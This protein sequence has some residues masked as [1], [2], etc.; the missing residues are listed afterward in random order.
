MPLVPAP[1]LP[2]R[3]LVRRLSALLLVVGLAVAAPAAEPKIAFDLPAAPAER[4]LKNFSAQSGLEVLFVTELAADVSTNAV[5]G[6]FTAKAAMDRMLAGTPLAASQDARTG[7]MKIARIAD[8]NAGRAAPRPSAAR[9]PGN[10]ANADDRADAAVVLSPF[11]VNAAGDVGYLAQNTLGGTRLNTALKDTAAPISVLTAEFLA[12]IAA[13]TVLEAMKYGINAH[14]DN[15]DQSPGNNAENFNQTF[16]NIRIRGL[17]GATRTQDYFGRLYETDLY[18]VERIDQSRGPNSILFGLGS[19]AGVINSSTKQAHYA[20]NATTLSARYDDWNDGYRASLDHNQVLLKNRLAVRLNLLKTEEAHWRDFGHN[21]QNRL[22]LAGKLKLH[23]RVELRADFER[24]QQNRYRPRPFIGLDLISYWQQQGRPIYDGYRLNDGNP[25][26]DLR[27]AQIVAPLGIPGLL[28]YSGANSGIAVLNPIGVATAFDARN[29]ARGNGV[30]QF[31]NP[32]FTNF[33]FIPKTADLLGPWISNDHDFKSLS[34]FLNV[35]VARDLNAEFAVNRQDY[36]NVYQG[37]HPNWLRINIDP[38]AYLPVAGSDGFPIANPYVGRYYVESFLEHRPQQQRV[39]SLRGTLSYERPLGRWARVR[40]A[41]LYERRT[42][43]TQV[44]LNEAYW[45]KDAAAARPEGVFN[46]NPINTANYAFHRFYLPAD[47]LASG[48]IAV[49]MPAFNSRT[50]FLLPNGTTQTA[51]SLVIP[52]GAIRNAKDEQDSLMAVTQLYLLKDRVVLTGGIRRE[53]LD[54]FRAP[55]RINARGFFEVAPTPATPESSLSATTHNVGAVVH[56]KPWL[57]VFANR[58]I[59]QDLPGANLVLNAD[60]KSL[61][62]GV[63]PPLREGKTQD[64]GV[65]FDLFQGRVFATATYYETSVADDLVTANITAGISTPMR[66][67]WQSLVDAGVVP[68]NQASAEIGAVADLTD[69]ATKGYEFEVI[70]NPTTNL[71]LSVNYATTAAQLSNVGKRLRPY[72][73]TH[74]PLW[75][76]GTN[77]DLLLAQDAATPGPDFGNSR[78]YVPTGLPGA[79][80]TAS[81]D[82]VRESV[83][84]IEDVFYDNLAIIDGT[85]FR[86]QSRHRLNFRAG[87]SFREGRLKGF[88]FG[89]GAR[90][91]KG[92]VIDVFSPQAVINGGLTD[93]S[94]GRSIAG[95]KIFRAELEQ[96]YDLS[97]GYQ[98]KLGARVRWRVQVNVNN[99]LDNQRLIV[100]L[101]NTNT[102]ADSRVLMRDPRQILVTNTFSF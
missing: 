20:R 100:N 17:P 64:F 5:K 7:A 42:S 77:G 78:D 95:R 91:Q 49:P 88:D 35:R 2:L 31:A 93:P 41:G 54:A 18:N 82:T 57:S 38:N 52:R 83:S 47:Q 12:D 46:P 66:L 53:Q 4:S 19:A 99:V 6:E 39:T 32:I 80:T 55:S 94:N 96:L 72:F 69:S 58:A 44:S 27:P 86:G 22:S 68:R 48:R 9:P 43:T 15:D 89:G 81:R 65:R 87:Y 71:R 13:T 50:T 76:A 92:R 33:A 25:A 14:E 60:P 97:L 61:D 59:S 36:D 63:R 101:L 16:G 67:I 8:P 70:A 10:P 90:L 26:N 84:D 75:L 30:A 37:A 98:R 34:A 24:S 45:V 56:L 102:E 51:E 79:T 74:K 40:A 73:D 62:Q 29:T 11:T 3:G 85:L 21:D 1:A 23:D 28:N